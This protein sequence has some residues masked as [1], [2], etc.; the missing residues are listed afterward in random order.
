MIT[1]YK[2]LTI[3]EY[4]ELKQMMAE[5]SSD[6]LSAQA[7]LIA[8]LNK[9]SEDEILSMPLTEYHKLVEKTAFLM[10]L[11][12]PGKKAP[13]TIK[14]GGYKLDV[15]TDIAK[16]TTAQ[17]IDFENYLGMK[18]KEQ[19]L[20]NIVA[21]FYVPQGKKYNVGYDLDEVTDLIANHVSIQDAV[22]V[23]FFFHQRYMNSIKDSLRYLEFKTKRMM[24]KEKDQTTKMKLQEALTAMKQYRDLLDAGTF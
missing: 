19:Y 17:Y 3:K 16:M 7:R 13:K 2:E 21:C 24:R 11:P 1:S 22:D 4:L 15:V 5:E 9:K 12:E 6:D 10:Q 8:F 14:L 18:D 23:C 20:A